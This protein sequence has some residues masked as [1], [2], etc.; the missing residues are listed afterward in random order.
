M[1]REG[2][3]FGLVVY[4]HASKF[5]LGYKFIGVFNQRMSSRLK[6]SDVFTQAI[7]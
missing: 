3:L 1:N 2:E 5:L 7:V 4:T 6:G